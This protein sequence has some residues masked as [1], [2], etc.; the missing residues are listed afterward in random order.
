MGE[1]TVE[2]IHLRAR[3]SASPEVAWAYLTDPARVAEWLT[4]ASPVGEVG[5]PYVLDFGAGS[6]VQGEIVARDEGRS[7]AHRWGWLDQAPYVE[8]LVTWTVRPVADGGAEIEL[9]HDGWAEVGAEVATRDD[10]EHYWQGY[11]DDLRERL[12]NVSRP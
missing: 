6:V 12:E 3:T 11:L 5:D 9:V 8:T 2:P 10:H 4:A 7:F 1:S